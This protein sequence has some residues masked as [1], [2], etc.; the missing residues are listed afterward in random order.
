MKT[1][2]KNTTK[3]IKTEKHLRREKYRSM[4]RTARMDQVRAYRDRCGKN[5][6]QA[7]S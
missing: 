1:D 5:T 2:Q 7:A 3:K 4:E 6:R